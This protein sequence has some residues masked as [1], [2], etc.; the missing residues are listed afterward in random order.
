MPGQHND[1][2]QASFS[3]ADNEGGENPGSL[4]GPLRRLSVEVP[5]TVGLCKLPIALENGAG[6]LTVY[7]LLCS[8]FGRA[9][10]CSEQECSPS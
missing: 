7:L 10:C 2:Q 6:P 8:P 4:C 1:V 5:A 9:P 3:R